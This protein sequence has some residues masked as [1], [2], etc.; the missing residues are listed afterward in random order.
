MKA[1]EKLISFITEKLT[2]E[3]DK[4]EFNRLLENAENESRLQ[5]YG[6]CKTVQKFMKK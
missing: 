5:G 2:N 6:D 3:S 1:R 4:Y